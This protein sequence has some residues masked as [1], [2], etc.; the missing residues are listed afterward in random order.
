MLTRHRNPNFHKPDVCI[1][2]TSTHSAETAE[3]LKRAAQIQ[4]E[5]EKL[6]KKLSKL[7][8]DSLQPG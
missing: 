3:K 1:S 7:L 8:G 2:F 4:R 5:I 6:R